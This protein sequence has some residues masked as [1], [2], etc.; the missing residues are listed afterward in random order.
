MD[1]PGHILM[2]P[3][4]ILL[5]IAEKL[6]GNEIVSFSRACQRFAE[7]CSNLRFVYIII[8]RTHQIVIFLLLLGNWFSQMTSTLTKKKL[9]HFLEIVSK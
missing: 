5:L 6:K 7:T 1:T 2:L 8:K 9:R 4:E 3:M